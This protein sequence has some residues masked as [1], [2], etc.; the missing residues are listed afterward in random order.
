MAPPCLGFKTRLSRI[1]L[2][3][4]DPASQSRFHPPSTSGSTLQTGFNLS[5]LPGHPF[6][7]GRSASVSV[8][9]LSRRS[10]GSRR[11]A[12][13]WGLVLCRSACACVAAPPAAGFR[14]EKT[15]SLVPILRQSSLQR[16]RDA[17]PEEAR[18]PRAEAEEPQWMLVC[19]LVF[20]LLSCPARSRMADVVE[21]EI[22]SENPFRL[23]P[24]TS[25][26]KL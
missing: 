18:R 24:Y 5:L 1:L 20:L 2:P 7:H 13:A 15:S 14:S 10:P 11:A 23:L 19:V 26:C 12:G 3:F 22:F 4:W 21:H 8:G 25:Q 17:S 6:H 9:F 16:G